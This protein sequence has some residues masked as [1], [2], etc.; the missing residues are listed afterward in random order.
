MPQFK[1]RG[2]GGGTGF[3]K[4]CPMPSKNV[5]MKTMC[6]S[7]FINAY[8]II[9]SCSYILYHFVIFSIQINRST[10]WFWGLPVPWFSRPEKGPGKGEANG[11]SGGPGF[12]KN[13]HFISILSYLNPKGFWALEIWYQ[14]NAQFWT[15]VHQKGSKRLQQIMIPDDR[16]WY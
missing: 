13:G 7:M 1:T 10:W 12:W 11:C 4:M 9:L 15:P 6:L 2:K 16:R 8:H 14:E 3:L 5:R